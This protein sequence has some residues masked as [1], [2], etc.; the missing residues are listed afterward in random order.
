VLKG[1]ATHTGDLRAPFITIESG[2]VF[3]GTAIMERKEPVE[4]K[5]ETNENKPGS[6]QETT[7]NEPS[8]AQTFEEKQAPFVIGRFDQGKR[9]TKDKPSEEPGKTEGGVDLSKDSETYG[10]P[11][12]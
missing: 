2:A 9:Q 10:K 7:I 8:V 4:K 1:T 11:R 5:I 3:N 12:F 6:E